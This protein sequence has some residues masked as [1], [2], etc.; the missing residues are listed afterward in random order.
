MRDKCGITREGVSFLNL[1][2]AAENIGLKTTA[3]K[4][5]IEDL[6]IKIPLPAIVHWDNNHFIVVLS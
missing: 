1:T 5:T 2:Y 3:L 6:I 4:C